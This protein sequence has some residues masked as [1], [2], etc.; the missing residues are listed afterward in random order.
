MLSLRTVSSATR[1]D[2]RARFPVQRPDAGLLLI[3]APVSDDAGWFADDEGSG[4]Q[5]RSGTSKLGCGALTLA[6]IGVRPT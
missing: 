6:L 2:P 1:R 3:N 4:P 5:L